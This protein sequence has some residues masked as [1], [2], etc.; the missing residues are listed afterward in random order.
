[1]SN[2]VVDR[3]GSPRTHPADQ[4]GKLYDMAAE[5]SLRMTKTGLV[6]DGDGWFILNAQESRWRDD[7]PLGRY[8]TFEGKRRFRQLGFNI[9]V[10]EPGQPLALYHRENA[11]EDFLVIQGRCLLIVEG[12]QR[13]LRAWDFFHCPPGTEHVIVGDGAEVAIVI[14]VGARGRGKGGVVYPVSSLAARLGASVERE[15]PHRRDAY[16]R[17]FAELPRSRWVRYPRVLPADHE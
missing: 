11:Q 14:A 15:T 2:A 6:P 7:G 8:C 12:E 1:M 16:R 5:A 10:L 9:N 13:R 17:L 3:E 4:A